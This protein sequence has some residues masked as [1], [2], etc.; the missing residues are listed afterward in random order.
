[1]GNRGCT[2]RFGRVALSIA[3]L[4]GVAGEVSACPNCKDAVAAQPAEVARMKNG[5]NWSV[6]FMMAMPFTLLGTG[7]FMV[8]RA[9]KRGVLPEM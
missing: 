6:L 7:V 3:L 1:M 4:L 8:T 2:Q 5:Y 9:V